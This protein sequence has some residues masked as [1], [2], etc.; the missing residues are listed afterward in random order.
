M[1]KRTPQQIHNLKQAL[2]DIRDKRH[3]F[4]D[5]TFSQVVM[6]LL[7]KLRRMQTLSI[8]DA[9]DAPLS[10]EVRLVTVMFVDIKDSTAMS[11]QIGETSDWKDVIAMADAHI[12]ALVAKWDGQIGQYLGDG[13]LCFFGA[14]HTRSDDALHAVSCA[15]AI[16]EKMTAYGEEVLERYKVDFSVR[17]GI[18]TGR[19]VVGFV[20]GEEKQELLALGPATNRASRLQMIADA[21]SILI[22][23]ATYNRV[24][25]EFITEAHEPVYLKGFADPVAY[26]EVLAKRVH[27]AL[28]FTSTTVGELEMPFVGRER[29]LALMTYLCDESLAMG[30][31]RAITLTGDVGVGKSRLLQQLLRSNRHQF[32][33]MTMIAQYENRARPYNLLR[34]FITAH[35]G[36][37][38]DL[39]D[40]QVHGIITKTLREFYDDPEAVAALGYLAD[41]PLFERPADDAVEL[42]ARWFAN[43]ATKNGLIIAV[44]NLQWV[45]QHAVRFLGR[46]AALTQHLPCVV[47]A[48]GSL[49]Y[50]SVHPRYMHGQLNHTQITLERLHPE[51]TYELINAITQY[52]AQVPSSLPELINDRVEGNPLFVREYLNMLFDGGVFQQVD[53]ARWRFN[54]INYDGA[55]NLLPTGLV[56]II[57]ARFDDLPLQARQ[58]LQV[59]SVAGITFWTAA[60]RE[61]SDNP[62]A[63]VL[64]EML[65]MRGMIVEQPRSQFPGETEY[66]FRH[67]LYREVAYNM[68]PRNQRIAYHAQFAGWLVERIARHKQLYHLLAEQ[69]HLSEAHDAALYTYVEA[70]EVELLSRRER[71]ALRLI[72]DGLDIARNIP[73]EIAV[74]MVSKLWS[75]RAQALN[76]LMRFEEASAASQ[77]ALRLLQE[78][79]DTQLAATRVL[80]QRMLGLAYASL[81]RYDEALKTLNRARQMLPEHATSQMSAVS[82]SLGDLNLRQGRLSEAQAYQRQAYAHATRA[83]DH[84]QLIEAQ[85]LQGVIDFQRGNMA[86]SLSCFE[87]VIEPERGALARHWHQALLFIGYIHLLLNLPQQALVH[88]EQAEETALPEAMA[89][90]NGLRAIALIEL[91]DAPQGRALLSA[92]QDKSS[93]DL[94]TRQ[95][96]ML[97]HITGLA[98]LGDY[99]ACSEQA[100]TFVDE[101]ARNNP[102]MRARGLRWLGYANHTL[103]S[104]RAIVS[105]QEA[106]TNENIYGGRDLWVCH[107]LIALC[108]YD[109]D[110]ARLHYDHAAR[111][112]RRWVDEL[113]QRPAL[114]AAFLHSERV[115]GIFALADA[116]R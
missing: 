41:F 37:M 81:G 4:G 8:S 103:G 48:A 42:G 116:P 3:L 94:Y 96:L 80:A 84:N 15:L 11:Q 9:A 77:S 66:Q 61:I 46:V 17:V 99:M 14:R 38:P 18:S 95:G 89:W 32:V 57:Q 65:A 5:E 25:G 97:L 74:P 73:R 51:E 45:D 87:A 22:D 83:A 26:H 101:V 35:C 1:V 49:I 98:L 88:F 64:L 40:A 110:H 43:L 58:M 75:L 28:R 69:F 107:Y 70:V 6:A 39:S 85:L 12:A 105:L 50:E 62:D 34:N 104:N 60:V 47:L 90:L 92:V 55:L 67:T 19:V 111:I 114:R 16:Q 56:G 20:G 113:G 10:D 68:L 33:Q 21:G 93:P 76:A 63:P 29:E 27:T 7:E 24:R 31:F 13:V 78:L 53:G 109:E 108:A 91:G 102:L 112:L 71:S 59:A 23:A 72:D 106:L 54:I 44:D 36:L 86:Q 79:P 52:V 115:Q 30:E 82:R 100:L 2:S